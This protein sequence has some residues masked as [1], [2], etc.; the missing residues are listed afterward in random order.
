MPDTEQIPV[1]YIAGC[2]RSGSTLLDILLGIH[3]DIESTGELTHLFLRGW[4]K[5]EYCACGRRVNACAYWSGV[6]ARWQRHGGWDPE[7]ASALQC[8]LERTRHIPILLCKRARKRRNGDLFFEMTHA[9]LAGIQEVSGKTVIVDSSKGPG[10]LLALAKNP[11]VK[12]QAIHLVRD[13][14][15]V[16][17]SRMKSFRKNE[18]AGIERDLRA[19]PA[20]QSSLDWLRGNLL[21]ELTLHLG[22]I[23]HIRIRYEDLIEHPDRTLTRIGQFLGMD[24]E[25]VAAAIRSGAAIPVGHNVAGSRIRMQRRIRLNPD[26]AWRA[27]LPLGAR[28]VFWSIA[29]LGAIRYGYLRKRACLAGEAERP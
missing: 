27:R 24:L 13:G 9:A 17:W 4:I 3:P 29:W 10:R 28:S 5:N 14:R 7:E 6:K 20:W 22:R 19:W 2:G 8:A 16:V 21:T 18:E 26:Y 23:K 1:I 11:H 12:L 25:P 15:G